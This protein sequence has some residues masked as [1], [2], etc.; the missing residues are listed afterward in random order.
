MTS[1][2]IQSVIIASHAASGIHQ[3][4]AYVAIQTT[5]GSLR[6]AALLELADR[7]LGELPELVIAVLG[8][9]TEARRVLISAAQQRHAIKRRQIAAQNDA[10][11]VATRLT[12][13][14]ENVRYQL[15][16]Q[17]D[18]RVFEIL[19]YLPSKEKYILLPLKLV[20]AADAASKQDEWWV[21]T[22]H[23]FG[24]RNFQRAQQRNRLLELHLEPLV[25][26]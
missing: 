6:N 17:R 16:P 12:E 21:Q 5:I 24:S 18:P 3:A 19:G 14:I 23:P 26:N 8:L 13:A 9:K 7:L 2:Q 25:S 11:L 20:S 15:L 1:V 10:E 22:A 4:A